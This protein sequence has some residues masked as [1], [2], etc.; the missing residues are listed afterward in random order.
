LELDGTDWIVAITMTFRNWLSLQL[1]VEYGTNVQAEV[2]GLLFPQPA[3]GK[4]PPHKYASVRMRCQLEG[5]NVNDTLI[6]GSLL[7]SPQSDQLN[8]NL[9]RLA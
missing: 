4:R 8:L 3:E 1:F 6:S 2:S 5:S 9:L 7:P